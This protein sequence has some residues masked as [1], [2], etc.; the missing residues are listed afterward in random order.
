MSNQLMAG[1]RGLIMGLAN[2]KSIA[3]GIAKALG[4]AGAE[5][6]FAYQ[7]EALK[8][9]V[10]RPR[11]RLL[12]R[13]DLAVPRTRPP[14]LDDRLVRPVG[15]NEGRE[16]LAL[17]FVHDFNRVEHDLRR[18][19]AVDDGDVLARLTPKVSVVRAMC[20]S[21]IGKGRPCVSYRAVNRALVR[22]VVRSTRGGN[23]S[24]VVW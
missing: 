24:F 23:Q 16:K 2:D 4:D 15:E 18:V 13:E 9:R 6:A 20:I 14:G 21:G 8:K 17:A 11:K 1:K 12:V 10:V 19:R 3:W 7:G 22:C 5:L